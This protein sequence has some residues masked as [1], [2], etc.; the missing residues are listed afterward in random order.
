MILKL[1]KLRCKEMV[2]INPYLMVKNGKE[3][4]ELYKEL[5][6]ALSPTEGSLIEDD[7]R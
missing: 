5:F 7:R 2:T 3:A 6:G 4:I 1:I